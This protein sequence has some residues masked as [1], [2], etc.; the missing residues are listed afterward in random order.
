MDDGGGGQSAGCGCQGHRAAQGGR[1]QVQGGIWSSA[2]RD[3]TKV[4]KQGRARL[5]FHW[6]ARL[7]LFRGEGRRGRDCRRR[8]S[9]L[10]GPGQVRRTGEE[11]HLDLGPGDAQR[12]EMQ[13]IE[14]QFFTGLDVP[15]PSG[16]GL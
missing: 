3:A 13:A 4:T 1:E 8:Q 15:E 7:W 16:S 6:E 11:S 10:C 12:K 2:R 9:A 5:A 14:F